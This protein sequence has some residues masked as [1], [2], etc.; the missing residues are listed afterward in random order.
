M[1]LFNSTL[2]REPPRSLTPSGSKPF[3]EEYCKLP[4]RLIKI[5]VLDRLQHMKHK[6]ELKSSDACCTYMLNFDKTF[7]HT[8]QFVVDDMV[9]VYNLPVSM[10]RQ[11]RTPTAEDLSVMPRSKKFE[12]YSVIKAMPYTFTNGIDLLHDFVAI[13]KVALA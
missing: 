10:C 1:T 3:N 11:G 12:P 6:A 8:R 9:Y 7:K 4:P 2:S 13:D 5:N